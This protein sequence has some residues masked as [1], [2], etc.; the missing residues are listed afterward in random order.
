MKKTMIVAWLVV[1]ALAIAAEPVPAELSERFSRGLRLFA[2]GNAQSALLEFQYVHARLPRPS[3][4]YN[5]ALVYADLGQPSESVAMADA[6]LADPGTLPAVRVDKL[7]AVR[8][9]QLEKLGELVIQSDVADV[10]VQVGGKIIGRTPLAGPVR[11]A[12]GRVFV[13]GQ[14]PKRKPA[15][16]ETMVAPKSQVAVKLEL[17]PLEQQLGFVRLRTKLPGADVL[18]DGVL[19]GQTPELL[20]VPV[21]PGQR[22]IALRREGYRTASKQVSI[23]EGAE[24]ELELDP[25]EDTTSTEG[26]LLTLQPSEDQVVVTVD[27]TR[28]GPYV[29]ALKLTPGPHVLL[30]ERGGFYSVERRVSLQPREETSLPI[31]FEPT[32]ELRASLVDARSRSRVLGWVGIGVGAGLAGGM[33]AILAANGSARAQLKAANADLET[34]YSTPYCT[35]Q[36]DCVASHA[37]NEAKIRGTGTGD[38]L[39]IAGLGVGAVALVTG[40]VLNLT[41]PDPTRYDR[42]ASDSLLELSLAPLPE[43]GLATASGRF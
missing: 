27:G 22:T 12:S 16:A 25:Q 37:D 28:K 33:V 19:V 39:A 30:L 14:A 34:K 36:F 35:V 29:A 41:A 18:V 3:V 10:E 31:T 23:G 40:V 32:A 6:V 17:A 26:A 1:S 4:T 9:A 42:P 38:A 8:T 20:R 15:F 21:E 11:V 43:G 24:L 2:T 5:L 7:K 13:G